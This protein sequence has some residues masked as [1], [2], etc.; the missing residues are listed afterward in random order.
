MKNETDLNLLQL[1]TKQKCG[2][3]ITLVSS[4]IGLAYEGISSFLYNKRHKA[5]HKAVKAIESKTAI[6][7]KQTHAIRKFYGHLWHL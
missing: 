3:I 5:L 4:F 7:Q 2:I 1:P 6:Q